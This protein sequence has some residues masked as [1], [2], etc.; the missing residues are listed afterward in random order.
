MAGWDF[1]SQSLQKFLSPGA[2]AVV[3]IRLIANQ[4]ENFAALGLH[5][6]Q[7][8]LQ[9]VVGTAEA[10]EQAVA[11]VALFQRGF[12]RRIRWVHET[13]DV[14]V[15]GNGDIGLPRS[16]EQHGVVAA[17]CFTLAALQERK[18]GV[19]YHVLEDLDKTGLHGLERF[20]VNFRRLQHAGSQP[21]GHAIFVF[22]EETVAIH[23]L[24]AV[25]AVRVGNAQKSNPEAG[26]GQHIEHAVDE[27]L[28]E[29]ELLV[30]VDVLAL[31]SSTAAA[32]ADYSLTTPQVTFVA[33]SGHG[34]ARQ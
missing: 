23:R 20:A 21:F 8:E 17:G 13:G 27:I 12:R 33:G 24:A 22:D 10:A 19:G 14:E 32:P 2:V 34:A 16:L 30:T 18:I 6:L 3:Q 11:Y 4:I 31:P 26:V 5:A 28:V 15:I 1:P 7:R 29:R 25:F 9:A